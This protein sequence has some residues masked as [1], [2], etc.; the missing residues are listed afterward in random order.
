MD[1]STTTVW[2]LKLLPV[3]AKAEIMSTSV[4]QCQTQPLWSRDAVYGA[5]DFKNGDK[6]H[7]TSAYAQTGSREIVNHV[8]ELATPYFLFDS[9]LM[10]YMD[11]SSTV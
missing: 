5:R 2:P 1:T 4:V 7:P 3:S 6:R 9:T 8:N 11:L 10:Q